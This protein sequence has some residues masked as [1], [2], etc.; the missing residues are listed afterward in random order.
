[1]YPMKEVENTFNH[2]E[3]FDGCALQCQDPY[4]SEE[5][6]AVASTVIWYFGV[7]TLIANG[8]VVVCHTF[9]SSQPERTYNNLIFFVNLHR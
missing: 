5:D 9:I 4:F 2:Y 8:W 1:M 3:G 7:A 6:H